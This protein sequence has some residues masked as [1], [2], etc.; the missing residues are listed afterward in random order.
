MDFL[1]LVQIVIFTLTKKWQAMDQNSWKL[2][3]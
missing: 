2:I 3:L 1:F